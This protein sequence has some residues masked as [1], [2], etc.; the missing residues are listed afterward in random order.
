MRFTCS[1]LAV[2]LLAYLPFSSYAQPSS[3][4]EPDTSLRYAT[5][6]KECQSFTKSVQKEAWV[7][8]FWGSDKSSL[9]SFTGLKEVYIDFRYKRIRF[10]SISKAPSRSIWLARLRHRTLQPSWEQLLIS[11]GSDYDFLT[12]AFKHNSLP[13]IF[14]VNP[15]GQVQRVRDVDHLR[16]VLTPIARDLPEGPYS[17]VNTKEV[18]DLVVEVSDP[19][20]E[21]GSQQADNIGSPQADWI[22]HTVRKN[23]TL[24]RIHVKYD[25]EVAELRS[26]NGLKNNNI[27][28]GQV[29]KIKRR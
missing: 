19:N 8:H 14:V 21:T 5:F 28:V 26:I 11:S 12:R 22:T 20:I 9:D 17:S 2:F 6:L 4:Y 10:I 23:E 25:I 29:L 16:T 1:L 13:G 27:K 24:W 3:G 18:P 7:V 15:Q